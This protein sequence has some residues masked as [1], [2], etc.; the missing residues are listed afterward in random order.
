MKRSGGD[1]SVWVVIHL[2][3]EAMVGISLYILISAK[4]LRLSYYCL[5]LLFYKIREKG[6]TGSAWK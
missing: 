2:C 5:R 6:R 4:T 3:I 1:E